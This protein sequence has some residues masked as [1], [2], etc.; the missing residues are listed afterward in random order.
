MT[1]FAVVGAGIAGLVTAWELSRAGRSVTVYEAA[2][3]VGGK[4]RAGTSAGAD[5]GAESF[6]IRT[7]AVTDLIADA[8]LDVEIVAPHP[9]GAHLVGLDEAGRVVRNPL[10][11]RT[12]LGLPADAAA[13]DV[14]AIIGPDGVTRA[15]QEPSLG[16]LVGPE[17]SL[18]DLARTRFG[19]AVADRLVDTLCRSVYSQPAANLTLSQV[20]PAV[21]AAFG[22]TGS[23]T[24]AVAEVAA[25]APAGAAVRG[26]RGGVWRLAAALRDASPDVVFR[27]GAPVRSLADLD[28]HVVLAAGEGEARRLLHLPELPTDTS[29]RVVSAVVRSVQLDARPVGSG[30]IIAPDVPTR[31][32]A[33]T[34][35]T[36]KW[37]WARDAAP[38]GCHV[39]RVSAREATTTDLTDPV[40]LASELTTLTGA[41]IAPADLVEIVETRWPDAVVNRDDTS[42]ADAAHDAGVSVVGAVVAGTGLVAVV[43]HARALART[44]LD[45]HPAFSNA[46]LEGTP[47]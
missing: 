3:T 1:E 9:G 47:A 35:V 41:R 27:T 44:L 40:V 29:V 17:P 4:L 26:V 13:P 37:D 7:S 24:A 23:L 19:D 38:D 33:L 18:Y 21:W 8:G 5:V 2:D 20:H 39:V 25:Q 6:A 10:P 30:V 31:A 43:T 16:P 34:H 42:V 46:P 45:E 28:G 15:L 32:K 12:V 11:G 22:R 36:A 14:A